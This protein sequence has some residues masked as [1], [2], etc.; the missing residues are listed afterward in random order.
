MPGHADA[1]A[2]SLAAPCSV[3]M[4]RLYVLDRLI[5]RPKQPMTFADRVYRLWGLGMLIALDARTVYRPLRRGTGKN[6]IDLYRTVARMRPDWHILAYH[7]TA[8]PLP[9]VLDETNIEPRHI[10][11]RGDRFHA[12]LRWRL[13]LAAWRDGADLLHCPSNHCPTWMPV[14]TL[15]TIHDL[16]PLDL[17]QGRAGSEV[18][19]FEQ[20][21]KTACRSAAG[22]IC[23]SQYTCDRLIDEFDAPPGSVT[24]NPWAADQTV[25]LLPPS[26]WNPVVQRYG[27][28]RRFV[29]HFGGPAPRK[30]TRRVLEAW[31]LAGSAVRRGHQLLIIGLDGTSL[32]D[33]QERVANMGIGDST[34]LFG[35]APEEDLPALLSAASVLMYPSL[36]E[37]FGLPVLDA[38]A[39]DTAVLSSNGTSLK[40]LA[41][42]GAVLVDPTDTRA[43]VA[44]MVKLLR[45]QQ[46]CKMLCATGRKRLGAYTWTRTAQRFVSAVERATGQ[47][48]IQR[49]AA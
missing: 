4:C 16:I 9:E 8:E 3:A 33:M 27:V 5:V 46:L 44:G 13:P 12:W 29:L 17:P 32:G 34:R 42:E 36:S 22:I 39:T 35:F 10:E 20:A 30:N 43:I 15:V 38:W 25:K 14:P 49:R 45:D 47:L 28:D 48:S 40:E 31:A 24:V 26:I 7:R 37:G 6:L 1:P 41:G 23:P 19:L 21:M 11:M 18:R 2:T